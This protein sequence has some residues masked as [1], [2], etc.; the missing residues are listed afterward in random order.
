MRKI[1]VS[2]GVITLNWNRAAD[3]IACI[4]SI[5]LQIQT[6]VTYI[7][8]DN[9]STDDQ[10]ALLRRSLP[11]ATLLPLEKN[12]GFAAGFNVGIEKALSLGCDLLLI[13]NNDTIACP[14]MVSELLEEIETKEI[15]VVAPVIYHHSKPTVI[16]SAGGNLLPFLATTVNAHSRSQNLRMPTKRTFLSGCCLLVRRE[17]L[18]SVGCFDERFFMYFEDLDFFVRLAKTKWIAKIVPDAKLLHKV[19]MS[20]GGEISERERYLMAYSSVVY[21]R[22]HLNLCNL[23]FIIPFRVASFLFNTLRMMKSCNLKGIKAYY[24]GTVDALI[25]TNKLSNRPKV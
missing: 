12:L 10:V 25:A 8:V 4:E 15:G 7:I 1:P 16:W 6:N 13:L 18:L 5:K 20:S 11:Y 3:T 9:G 17:V 22:K 19:S 14:N 21:Y 23:I 2:L 24:R